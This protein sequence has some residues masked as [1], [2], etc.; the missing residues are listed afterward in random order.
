[1]GNG[2]PADQ[3]VGLI[4]AY[5]TLNLGVKQLGSVC[6]VVCCWDHPTDQKPRGVLGLVVGQGLSLHSDPR[7]RTRLARI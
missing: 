1:M 6:L 4:A 7:T 5:F 2:S 3:R